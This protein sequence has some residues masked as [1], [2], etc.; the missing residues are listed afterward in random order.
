[1]KYADGQEVRLGDRV[2][3]AHDQGGIV[4]CMI[5]TAEYTEKYP[6][7]AW[8]YLQNGVMIEFPKFGLIHYPE[9]PEPD[10][11]LI[12]RAKGKP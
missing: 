1:M 12:E 5:D 3:L 8:S 9:G 2:K 4:V 7:D 11:E 6:K 10:I